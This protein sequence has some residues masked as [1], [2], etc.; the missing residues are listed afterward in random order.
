MKTSMMAAALVALA[1]GFAS[2]ARADFIG[3]ATPAFRGEPG[4]G[5]IQFDSFNEG[6]LNGTVV[7]SPVAAS[8]G[9][10]TGGVTQTVRLGLPGGVLPSDFTGAPTVGGVSV[11]L[12][13]DAGAWTLDLTA[14]DET[15]YAVLQVKEIE[16]TGLNSPSIS[17][18][19]DG[20]APTNA[21]VT[22]DGDDDAITTFSWAL[23]A[24]IPA[25]TPFAITINS[26]PFSFDSY[27]SF[28]VDVAATPEPASVALVGLGAVAALA[29]RRRR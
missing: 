22:D 3:V 9:G 23:A 17:V 15:N 7:S 11:Y 19:L 28:T 16:G 21:Y 14:A 24:P 2:H 27:D 20:A 1:A 25:S 8:G 18:L 26:A 6:A 13:S 29:R 10:L 5:F 4:T 12:H